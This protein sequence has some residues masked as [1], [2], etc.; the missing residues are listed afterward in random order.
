MN[1]KNLSDD[2]VICQSNYYAIS[3]SNARA[4]NHRIFL[5]IF[6]NSALRKTLFLHSAEISRSLYFLSEY[7]PRSQSF[8]DSVRRRAEIT[9]RNRDGGKRIDSGAQ[10]GVA[11]RLRDRPARKKLIDWRGRS[12][13]CRAG[14]RSTGFL[15]DCSLMSQTWPSNG[16]TTTSYQAA[17]VS[18]NFGAIAH[19][20]LDVKKC[21]VKICESDCAFCRNANRY[22]NQN[23]KN[24][25]KIAGIRIIQQAITIILYQFI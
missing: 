10:L 20:I 22:F 21:G 7:L 9:P 2:S 5:F 24:S 18:S 11:G 25:E 1:G 8:D 14:S 17:L 19:V 12:F 23:R 6:H 13:C 4:F 15:K 16:P 3:L